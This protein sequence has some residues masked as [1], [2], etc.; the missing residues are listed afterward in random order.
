M[1]VQALV[2]DECSRQIKEETGKQ[3]SKIDELAGNNAELNAEIR[4][5]KAMI[6]KFVD[7]ISLQPDLPVTQNL[8]IN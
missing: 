1:T 4:K 7:M 3:K 6:G 5:L 2:L 8:S